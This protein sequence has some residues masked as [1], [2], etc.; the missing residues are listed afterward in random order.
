M[1]GCTGSLVPSPPALVPLAHLFLADLAD[2][3]TYIHTYIQAY[4]HTY[5]AS[6]LSLLANLGGGHL[7]CRRCD[8][9]V[10]RLHVCVCVGVS[11]CM[12]V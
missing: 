2:L 9:L 7:G 6:R 12:D 3:H 11:V 10:F 5:N 1:C 8:Y 4:R